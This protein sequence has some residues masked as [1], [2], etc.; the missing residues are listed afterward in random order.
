MLLFAIAKVECIAVPLNIRLTENEL[1]FQLK[2]SGTTVLFV[3][4]TFQN[5]ALSMQKVSYVQRVISITSLKE[6]EDRKIDNFVE[7]NESASFIICYTSGT[8][9]K[10]KGAV[11][12]QEN[13]FGMR[14]IIHL[15]LINYTS[16]HCII[17]FISYWWYWLIRISNFIC[18]RCNHCSKKFEPT[19]ALSMIE[20]HKVT[21]VMGVPT[22]HQA[23]INCSK[24]ETTNLQ[25]VRWFYNGGAPCP[26][27]LMR[28]F[29]DRGFLFGQGF[30]MT[31]TS[32]TVF[33]LS[34]ED[35]RRKVGSIGKPVLFCDY[36]LI[37]ENKN[38]VEVGEVGELLIRGP[39]VMKEYWNR[40]DATEETIQDGWLCTGDLARVDE[41][42]F[43]YIVGRKKMIISGGENIYPLEVEQ[44]I[45]KLSDVYE[46][47][48]VGRQHVK[49]GEIP[50]AFIVKRVAVY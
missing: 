41:D 22:I 10:P 20:K 36:E 13:M 47:A 8:T 34:E 48:V 33:M 16:L 31:E 12:T 5:M 35:A 28:E 46:V 49:W 23:L 45:N 18:R 25:S 38:K 11:L 1:I 15:R 4:E 32:P 27:E 26:E 24:F 30:G 17:A 50:I 3:E 43:V 37:D 6:I 19:K 21:V 7:I 29:I 9:G 2:D 42:G 40:P 14:L 39:N 44:V